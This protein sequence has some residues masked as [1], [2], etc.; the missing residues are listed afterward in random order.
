M[1]SGYLQG[2]FVEIYAWYLKLVP[3]VV[4]RKAKV[5]YSISHTVPIDLR[6]WPEG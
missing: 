6:A 4:E 3:F 5:K 2:S 1:G